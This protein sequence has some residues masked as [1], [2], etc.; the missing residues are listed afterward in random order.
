MSKGMNAREV[1]NN[2]KTDIMWAEDTYTRSLSVR[3]VCNDLSIFDWWNERISVRQL[4][5]MQSFLK[6]AIKHGYDGYVCF[7]VGAAG[8]AS[9]MWA[10]KRESDTGYS[11]DGEFLYRS[12][13]SSKNWW[14]AADEDGTLITEKNGVRWDEYNT[15]NKLMAA[16]A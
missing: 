1:L 9:G 11:P 16:M 2:L 10:H 6:T 3:E 4:K 15:V 12:F 13:Y 8:C 14:D 5:A 7:K